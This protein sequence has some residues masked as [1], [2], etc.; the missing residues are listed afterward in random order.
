MP[1]GRKSAAELLPAVYDELRRMARSQ[2]HKS[3]G[4]ITLDSADLAN[5][6]CLHFLAHSDQTWHDSAMFRAI[7]HRKMSQIL[8]DY[9]K[10]RNSQ[11]RGGSG[12][13]GGDGTTRGVAWQRVPIEDVRVEWGPHHYSLPDLYDAL[14]TLRRTDN[15]LAGALDL[16]WFAGCSTPEIAELL[17]VTPQTIRRRLHAGIEWLDTHL[18]GTPSIVDANA[19]A[20]LSTN[21]ATQ[22]NPWVDVPPVT[23]TAYPHRIGP[24]HVV[25]PIATGGMGAVYLV[26][27]ED[28]SARFAAKIP[29][30][31]DDNDRLTRRLRREAGILRELAHPGIGRFVEIREERV[32]GRV[33]P[34]IITEYIS[35]TPI[36]HYA[37][38]HPL[39]FR[40]R[41]ILLINV[42]RAIQHAHERGIV[43]LDLK[44]NNILVTTAGHPMVIDFGLADLEGVH[45]SFGSRMGTP[46]YA[47]PEQL[48]GDTDHV[49][50]ASD[51][52]A[53]AV[54]GYELLA[55]GLAS[56]QIDEHVEL[57]ATLMATLRDASDLNPA[58]RPPDAG[59]LANALAAALPENDRHGVMPAPDQS[60]L[61][62]SLRRVVTAR[63]KM[64]GDRETE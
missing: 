58:K 39:D 5:E 45:R 28:K 1:D 63:I 38:N 61:S 16:Y 59:A 41:L 22:E 49:G 53:L 10:R 7:A 9:L 6:T 27:N 36:T 12:R 40:G 11:K 18:Q 19:E 26:T 4:R 32:A 35:G 17:D 29:L 2:L 50:G 51:V 43:H 42:A 14:E 52:Y 57:R 54:I 56:E 62:S 37:R 24:Y 21:T 47:S 8:V 13:R 31:K 25:R 64:R 44:P 60:A 55:D 34:V 15:K 48:T 33:C 3:V 23:A 30:V 20:G 46:I